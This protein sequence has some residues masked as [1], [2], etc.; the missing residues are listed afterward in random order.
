MLFIIFALALA[1]QTTPADPLR[2]TLPER[3]N[4]LLPPELQK[5]H[6]TD[7]QKEVLIGHFDSGAA[8]FVIYNQSASRPNGDH[9]TLFL[10][11]IGKTSLE[12][13]AIGQSVTAEDQ[14]TLL[15][16][17]S[18]EDLA[19]YLLAQTRVNSQK[20]YIS[21]FLFGKESEFYKSASTFWGMV[22]SFQPEDRSF[23]KFEQPIQ[24]E[25]IAGSVFVFS[26]A[27]FVVWLGFRKLAQLEV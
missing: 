11:A 22:N 20:G 25:L 3:G 10:K 23:S 12:T 26:L 4:F 1:K 16:V 18:P 15:R 7:S 9:N 13:E 27:I 24:R 2:L 6:W 17:V 19:G 14:V 21:F 5:F 8:L